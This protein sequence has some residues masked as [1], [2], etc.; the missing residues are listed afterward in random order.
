MSGRDGAT[1][2]L[3]LDSKIGGQSRSNN[4]HT[5]EQYLAREQARYIQKDRD[6]ANTKC[7]DNKA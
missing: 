5:V 2:F 7:R 6:R 1:T 3:P 4:P